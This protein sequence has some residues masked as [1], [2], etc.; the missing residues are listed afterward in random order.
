MTLEVNGGKEPGLQ[1]MNDAP[2]LQKLN[3]GYLGR[4]DLAKDSLLE[5]QA[6]CRIKNSKKIAEI[7]FREIKTA[8]VKKRK[9][10]TFVKD[11]Y[12]K[13]L[14][15]HEFHQEIK[16]KKKRFPFSKILVKLVVEY[17]QLEHNALYSAEGNHLEF[18]KEVEN[19]VINLLEN[20]F[21]LYDKKP[22]PARCVYP[23]SLFV[24]KVLYAVSSEYR[25]DNNVFG[26]LVRK[27]LKKLKLWDA[28]QRS[29][30]GICNITTSNPAVRML[31]LYDINEI[32]EEYDT[33][34]EE[35][36]TIN[37]EL[38][39]LSLLTP[40]EKC[41]ATPSNK[42]DYT[43]LEEKSSQ[44]ASIRSADTVVNSA[45]DTICLDDSDEDAV[46]LEHNDYKSAKTCNS[47]LNK[48]VKSDVQINVKSSVKLEAMQSTKTKPSDYLSKAR[49]NKVK[50]RCSKGL[51]K[52][53]RKTTSRQFD[54]MDLPPS[55]SQCSNITLKNG[56]VVKIKSE[57]QIQIVIEEDEDSILNKYAD[58]E[59]K[60]DTVPI[61]PEPP[62][63]AR[64]NT[65]RSRARQT[66]KPVV[67]DNQVNEISSSQ[68]FDI[69]NNCESVSR[70]LDFSL[71][72]VEIT[73]TSTTYPSYQKH[74]NSSSSIRISKAF[75]TPD[76]N[77]IDQVYTSSHDR[78]YNN[79]D[80][81]LTPSY[82][83]S[84][85]EEKDNN[86]ENVIPNLKDVERNDNFVSDSHTDTFQ[87]KI[88][89][90]NKEVG[91]VLVE[92]RLDSLLKIPSELEDLNPNDDSQ[93][94][95]ID[96]LNT[97][98]RMVENDTLDNLKA[99]GDPMI[100]EPY[101]VCNTSNHQTS[102][103][104]NSEKRHTANNL[105]ETD[106]FEHIS[107]NLSSEKDNSEIIHK[108]RVVDIDNQLESCLSSLNKPDNINIKN[109]EEKDI[110][111]NE[112][113]VLFGDINEKTADNEQEVLEN[114]LKDTNN[115]VAIVKTNEAVTEISK[116]NC[117]IQIE[118]NNSLDKGELKHAKSNEGVVKLPT[119]ENPSFEIYSCEED[120]D[121]ENNTK[122]LC[123]P[124]HNINDQNHEMQLETIVDVVQKEGDEKINEIE[125]Q[126][127]EKAD[128]INLLAT[129]NVEHLSHESFTPTVDNRIS[130]SI[131]PMDVPIHIE[132][133]DYLAKNIEKQDHKT[134]KTLSDLQDKIDEDDSDTCSE[135]SESSVLT[136]EKLVIHEE[137]ND[138]LDLENS[139]EEISESALLPSNDIHKV[140]LKEDVNI[141]Q[142]DAIKDE[143]LLED[144]PIT[145]L[146]KNN[147]S[148][149][150]SLI[151]EHINSVANFVYYHSNKEYQNTS[152]DS[153][154]T[155]KP[156]QSLKTSDL[157]IDNKVTTT[158]E[159]AKSELEEL[160]NSNAHKHSCSITYSIP[161]S[162]GDLERPVEIRIEEL[163]EKEIF[164]HH[165]LT[166]L[167]ESP[168]VS[169]SDVL[170]E[171]R[172]SVLAELADKCQHLPVTPESKKNK[173]LNLNKRARSRLIIPNAKFQRKRKDNPVI[174]EDSIENDLSY[175]ADEK[176]SIVEKD[177]KGKKSINHL[178]T[179]KNQRLKCINPKKE[180]NLKNRKVD[181]E[182]VTVGRCTRSKSM[183][184]FNEPLPF[185]GR[186]VK[187]KS[188]HDDVSEVKSKRKA[189]KSKVNKNLSENLNENKTSTDYSIEN[190]LNIPY[191]IRNGLTIA[192]IDVPTPPDDV[193]LNLSKKV[194]LNPE[195]SIEIIGDKSEK[196][197]DRNS[198]ETTMPLKTTKSSKSKRK[199]NQ[200][201]QK[202]IE[203]INQQETANNEDEI[204]GKNKPQNNKEKSLLSSV[205]NK[206]KIGQDK[207]KI[208]QPFEDLMNKNAENSSSAS[209]NKHHN[210]IN[211]TKNE[212]K[213]PVF[214]LNEVGKINTKRRK[215]TRE[216]KEK[217]SNHLN[218]QDLKHI[219]E[220]DLLD[221]YLN[222]Q[223]PISYCNDEET[224]WFPEKRLTRKNGRTKDTVEDL[225]EKKINKKN[226]KFDIQSQ[227]NIERELDDPS[228]N[229]ENNISK[230]PT[231]RN[232]KTNSIL[233]SV[234][235]KQRCDIVTNGNVNGPFNLHDMENE[236]QAK[237]LFLKNYDLMEKIPRLNKRPSRK[238]GKE[239]YKTDIVACEIV[240][241][242]LSKSRSTR[243]NTRLRN[244]ETKVKLKNKKT[245]SSERTLNVLNETESELNVDSKLQD[246]ES[247]PTVIC[248][249]EINPETVLTKESVSSESL[250]DKGAI[251]STPNSIGETK[252][253]ESCSKSDET[254]KNGTE[255][256]LNTNICRV[257]V[258]V[259][260]VVES[261]KESIEL[262]EE[263]PKIDK[264]VSE[265]LI[266]RVQHASEEIIHSDYVDHV[267]ELEIDAE[268]YN[269]NEIYIEDEITNVIEAVIDPPMIGEDQHQIVEEQVNEVIDTSIL[270]EEVNK[271]EVTIKNDLVIDS[272]E[273]Q[274]EILSKYDQ[275][276]EEGERNSSSEKDNFVSCEEAEDSIHDLS[277]NEKDNENEEI[278]VTDS[279]S[280]EKSSF[281][282]ESVISLP[283][284]S[285]DLQNFT[286]VSAEENNFSNSDVQKA[287]SEI[288]NALAQESEPESSYNEKVLT[289]SIESTQETLSASVVENSEN[290]A[291]SNVLKRKRL[292]SEL[293]AEEQDEESR[294][295]ATPMSYDHIIENL[296]EDI[297]CLF[298]RKPVVKIRNI[299]N[300]EAFRTQY[301]NSLRKPT[302]NT[303]KRRIKPCR[304]KGLDAIVVKLATSL[305]KND[306]WQINKQKKIQL[307]E[308]FPISNVSNDNT[309]KEDA[310]KQSPQFNDVTEETKEQE[311]SNNHGLD[312]MLCQQIQEEITNTQQIQSNE[313]V[314]NEIVLEN[315]DCVIPAV[316]TLEKQET[317]EIIKDQNI[318][319]DLTTVLSTQMQQSE[320]MNVPQMSDS[321][322]QLIQ[323]KID[324]SETELC[325]EEGS[326]DG[327]NIEVDEMK[328]NH[329][330]E[331]MA[332]E[333]IRPS[334]ENKDLVEV[335]HE[336]HS[337]VEVV[338]SSVISEENVQ[339]PNDA[340][341]GD[342]FEDNQQETEDNE[343]DMICP[344]DDKM[345]RD[346]IDEENKQIIA[347][348]PLE[349]IGTSEVVNNEADLELQ[350]SVVEE[351]MVQE[352][353]ES[354]SPDNHNQQD[355]NLDFEYSI[356]QQ[357]EQIIET[358]QKIET[359]L[360]D[361]SEEI[362]PTNNFME[363][364]Q[365]T[366]T[367]YHEGTKE[368]DND[369]IPVEFEM[370]T[371]T[372]CD[373]KENHIEKEKLQEKVNEAATESFVNDNSIS[374]LPKP[375]VTEAFDCDAV[376]ECSKDGQFEV[377]ISLEP[378]HSS[379]NLNID[380]LSKNIENVNETETPLT[381]GLIVADSRESTSSIPLPTIQDEPKY[382]NEYKEILQNPE[383]N[384]P[385]NT[386]QISHIEPKTLVRFPTAMNEDDFVITSNNS[387]INDCTLKVRPAKEL[388]EKYK[389]MQ[390][391]SYD[392]S[393][394][395][396]DL[397]TSP[398]YPVFN[399][400]NANKIEPRVD[401]NNQ[402]IAASTEN[403]QS[404][405]IEPT[406]TI[407]EDGSYV[408]RNGKYEDTN[409]NKQYVA[410]NISNEIFT[411]PEI[412]EGIHEK[413]TSSETINKNEVITNSESISNHET[414]PKIVS[415]PNIVPTPDLIIPVQTIHEFN[416][417]N[418]LTTNLPQFNTQFP[419]KMHQSTILDY[420]TQPISNSILNVS[421]DADQF[422]S[423][424]MLD[425]RLPYLDSC[426]DLLGNT[427]I[428]NQQMNNSNMKVMPPLN[429]EQ[430]IPNTNNEMINVEKNPNLEVSGS[431]SNVNIMNAATDFNGRLACNE[432]I[433]VDD[434]QL[435]E[436][437]K[438]M[439][440]VKIGSESSDHDYINYGGPLLVGK[441]EQPHN[442]ESPEMS[443]SRQVSKRET[444]KD[445]DDLMFSFVEQVSMG[446]HNE[447]PMIPVSNH[448][449]LVNNMTEQYNS[450]PYNFI[451]TQDFM[452]KMM[453]NVMQHHQTS[454]ADTSG[455]FENTMTFTNDNL[456]SSTR[457][458]DSNATDFTINSF[459][460]SDLALCD[461]EDF[462]PSES[463]SPDKMI[464]NPLK[465]LHT[466]PKNVAME[467]PQKVTVKVNEYEYASTDNLFKDETFTCPGTPKLNT[468]DS[469]IEYA[470]RMKEKELKKEKV[471]TKAEKKLMEW[472]DA[473][474]IRRNTRTPVSAPRISSKKK[475][476]K[477]QGSSSS[478]DSNETSPDNNQKGLNWKYQNEKP[479]PKLP[480]EMS[481][482][483][484][485]FI[486]NILS[487]NLE[488]QE[489][490]EMKPDKLAKLIF[491]TFDDTDLLN[492][493][494]PNI[495]ESPT[496][497]TVKIN[498]HEFASTDDLYTA[499]TKAKDRAKKIERDK[500]KP[501]GKKLEFSVSK[502]ADASSSLNVN[503]SRQSS[504]PDP[505]VSEN[506]PQ[507]DQKD[508]SLDKDIQK[509]DVKNVIKENLQGKINDNEQ[510]KPKTEVH[511][512]VVQKEKKFKEEYKLQK[513][514][515]SKEIEKKRERSR[516]NEKKESRSLDS[517]RE[518]TQ[519]N[520]SD[521]RE[522]PGLISTAMPIQKYQSEI[523][524]W[525]PET[526]SQHNHQKSKSSSSSQYSSS[527]PPSNTSQRDQRDNTRSE[528]RSNIRSSSTYLRK[529]DNLKPIDKSNYNSNKNYYPSTSSNY[530]QQPYYQR[531]QDFWKYDRPPSRNEQRKPSYNRPERPG[532]PDS[533][534]KTNPR[535]PQS[536][537]KMYWD[538][539]NNLNRIHQSRS[540]R[541]PGNDYLKQ[542]DQR[543]NTSYNRIPQ[544][545][546]ERNSMETHQY[547]QL[548]SAMFSRN[549]YDEIKRRS[550]EKSLR[551][552]M[553]NTHERYYQLSRQSGGS[554]V[555]ERPSKRKSPSMER[556]DSAKIRKFEDERKEVSNQ[557]KR[558]N[559]PV[560]EP[561][562]KRQKDYDE[563]FSKLRE[564][565]NI[566][567][568]FKLK[569][570]NSNN[571]SS[572][573][574]SN[575]NWFEKLP[576]HVFLKEA[577]Y[578]TF[579]SVIQRSSD[580]HS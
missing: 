99:S 274:A 49:G 173:K 332:V 209:N 62:Q 409:S 326:G 322:A 181:E 267:E 420:N 521:S 233:T 36:Q 29:T 28:V 243:Q 366:E 278:E 531:Q 398:N 281:L 21:L 318:S 92:N 48:S 59:P 579:G 119:M 393:S 344:D 175:T 91:E 287:N 570:S 539:K 155:D 98:I 509:K 517:S 489:E 221:R 475:D 458:D 452:N 23:N 442:N 496:R 121:N 240:E 84:N 379:E 41:T 412:I 142:E 80:S 536:N 26:N 247:D 450:L 346:K 34:D 304:S 163:P 491:A 63:I 64:S 227:K 433:D 6:E 228:I 313:E 435:A 116:E 363:E 52:D 215:S 263:Q 328:S 38:S 419:Q 308:L 535:N 307:D 417:S 162:D 234:V 523:Q 551:N 120:I 367:S 484:Q 149:T 51:V 522:K 268:F 404:C 399:E 330:D 513:I 528:S 291:E 400:V 254:E 431:S 183:L 255:N 369:N 461:I 376:V 546:S 277:V 494:A 327:S 203:D 578:V 239:S 271:V 286:Q 102:N 97:M 394:S 331:E 5:L 83:T 463:I 153:P 459:P 347:D 279:T 2:S 249:T 387:F 335:L 353:T 301:I 462:Y 265:E 470:K 295:K 86:V 358:S 55:T 477:G 246:L 152:S 299:S 418:M 9:S 222:E 351:P 144:K 76:C 527:K 392:T 71:H 408:H 460:L 485:A 196:I 440:F 16:E 146:F 312:N 65:K 50:N 395:D 78:Y 4:T 574:S 134:Q 476:D 15:L 171:N 518:N 33:D 557:R 439:G 430:L 505:T 580:K 35:A 276:F 124:S 446:A 391:E 425:K 524:K 320:N 145:E 368:N 472:A 374:Q 19:R 24:L 421:F 88:C 157:S 182:V 416:N 109:T 10:Q 105:A 501:V 423:D 133:K 464:V 112:G 200:I 79:A 571:G 514:D 223:K 569:F 226:K 32:P 449:S 503:E 161:N 414:I 232:K 410:E 296:P 507:L 297:S 402:L 467:V 444:C 317:Y 190:L 111:Q 170:H 415:S 532:N 567:K 411:N 315:L 542:N 77:S 195:V 54:L 457:I 231:R 158:I 82:V 87:A 427:N 31:S 454:I 471:R 208:W 519:R 529:E 555:Q 241:E 497:V 456:L 333:E 11:I 309:I 540:E 354:N 137:S 114:I 401:E 305:K 257:D 566:N 479:L 341:I 117:D 487:A 336:S 259:A 128:S 211:S 377:D 174:D 357:N 37:C 96:L 575:D 104:D 58:E 373:K 61:P 156:P 300:M 337:G 272:S 429:Q 199:D 18:E 319:S 342:I 67:S 66:K 216:K 298:K 361:T 360:Q 177:L 193:P 302:L 563:I 136:N 380:T 407:A 388:L 396:Y 141:D 245:S 198:Q 225:I 378:I 108:D 426:S 118:L 474:P 285:L 210:E 154:K 53:C 207:V 348:I 229:E 107:S 115:K 371:E 321:E 405:V 93:I 122:Y 103:V 466:I 552:Q 386:S 248:K 406:V 289:E 310:E 180:N 561:S 544:S 283:N 164:P 306:L 553:N 43:S 530:Q 169:R 191:T 282:E 560:E 213:E 143:K 451:D 201:N 364:T 543:N 572:S 113:D 455:Q 13:L 323:E 185:N 502:K 453:G 172:L 160:Y 316:E 251:E 355:K 269:A 206:D 478:D 482:S 60:I 256:N 383:I 488:S 550:Y 372:D 261:L 138:D 432:T 219:G 184:L 538:H 345:E 436:K 547:S 202:N 469:L 252:E 95:I 576:E 45:I 192:R 384:V 123:Q 188:K 40:T 280:Q 565:G 516:S 438:S 437:V 468:N 288:I 270:K 325:H 17:I 294:E 303:T 495:L 57:H 127:T 290:N 90:V 483:K 556:S 508:T 350:T 20:M 520:V 481:I 150:N 339:K 179:T 568:N 69:D 168:K 329:E 359:P 214:N 220:E 500:P 244:K 176:S 250:L 236:A 349:Q 275:N 465:T 443:P 46:L 131:L 205:S 68:I 132:G 548:D 151:E 434:P 486:E 506:M 533:S 311:H 186:S 343:I 139:N 12:K 510:T 266:E 81:C 42:P 39:R 558:T 3:Q 562:R 47:D 356:S 512:K 534:S 56:T 515:D 235:E 242:T 165:E 125:I 187:N 473:F 147:S 130:P 217:K 390:D 385:N 189:N 14:F 382:D 25:C 559:S 490:L 264:V 167:P 428:L 253:I 537:E 166:S 362:F 314:H 365:P 27:L 284:T 375:Q 403:S 70:D 381:S 504:R 293:D 129:K 126:D 370:L 110:D 324:Q 148:T 30:M 260:L 397:Q 178:K 554:K 441:Y 258:E 413:I 499:F 238:R 352:H 218:L 448:G 8:S 197:C 85:Y 447:N 1:V 230:K 511:M 106:N 334:V 94:I 445:L 493:D 73:S 75:L 273:N 212:E 577:R 140:A 564:E 338:N 100:T 292:I 224:Q 22:A 422:L 526:S 492:V 498:K 480:P 545:R 389:F 7:L 573:Q 424:V 549:K 159:E 135:T 74:E 340:V 541:V 262:Q 204:E 72:S 237:E 44:D 89:D 101:F 525:R 194:M